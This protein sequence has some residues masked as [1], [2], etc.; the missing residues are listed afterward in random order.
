MLTAS[1][2]EYI[3]FVAKAM[4]AKVPVPVKGTITFTGKNQL[5]IGAKSAAGSKLRMLPNM[6]LSHINI[7]AAVH[8]ADKKIS[9]AQASAKVDV[10]LGPIRSHTGLTFGWEDGETTMSGTV[11]FK[12]FKPLPVITIE[13]GKV[14]IKYEDGALTAEFSA[15]AKLRPIPGGNVIPMIVTADFTM[16]KAPADFERLLEVQGTPAL[17][18]V[19]NLADKTIQSAQATAQHADST[20]QHAKVYAQKHHQEA[21]IQEASPRVS[22]RARL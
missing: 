13:K 8:M 4:L 5:T 11:L 1:R 6:M 2:S 22:P 19:V 12:T 9:M 21:D 16:E 18:K 10:H 15:A 17:D 7:Q 20:V 14:D 3:T